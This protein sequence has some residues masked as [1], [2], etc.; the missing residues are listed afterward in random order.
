MSIPMPLSTY[1]NGRTW[2]LFSVEFDT[3]DGKFETYIYALSMEHAVAMCAELRE[4]ARISGQV[5][6]VEKA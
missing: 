6:Q 2:Y 3:A 5:V 4:T 1:I